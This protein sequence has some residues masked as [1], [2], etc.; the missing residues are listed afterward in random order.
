MGFS[1]EQ[2]LVERDR[3][4]VAPPEL[5]DSSEAALGA[6]ARPADSDRRNALL[7][8]AAPVLEGIET[9]RHGN[10]GIHPESAS[11]FRHK[12]EAAQVN[13]PRHQVKSTR[14][15]PLRASRDLHLSILAD[16]RDAPVGDQHGGG[17][18][19]LSIADMHCRRG[20]HELRRGRHRKYQAA[21]HQE[22]YGVD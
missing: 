1:P 14:I 16:L 2:Q 17:L 15:D 12:L 7:T 8:G 9:I 21:G 10:P 11:R 13:H 22:K 18:Q 3:G 4:P 20:D 6:T 5:Q 19:Y